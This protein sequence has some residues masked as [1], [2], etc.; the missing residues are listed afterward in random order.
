MGDPTNF[1]PTP[2]LRWRRGTDNQLY[3]EQFWAQDL[4]TYMR[5]LAK[6][7]WRLVDTVES[8]SG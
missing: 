4:P 1:V 6:G 7:E 3:L 2:K 5:D 8:E